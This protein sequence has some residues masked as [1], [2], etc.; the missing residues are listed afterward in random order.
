MFHVPLGPQYDS[1]FKFHKEHDYSGFGALIPRLQLIID[2]Q[3]T[4]L[5]IK[6][7]KKPHTFDRLKP[8]NFFNCYIQTPHTYYFDY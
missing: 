8:Y 3:N 4:T 7:R 6:Y 5:L 1:T 2:S